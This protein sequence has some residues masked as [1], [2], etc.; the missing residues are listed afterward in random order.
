[1]WLKGCIISISAASTFLF[2]WFSLAASVLEFDD[3]EMQ[4]TYKTVSF[5]EI[6]DEI[7]EL[8]VLVLFI[9]MFDVIFV[10]SFYVMHDQIT[11][12]HKSNAIH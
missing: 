5:R 9:C 1:M 8:Q 7:N 3:S 11:D 12:H 6:Q 4:K 2:F 10:F